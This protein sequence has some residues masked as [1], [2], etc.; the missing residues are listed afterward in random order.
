M[1]FEASASAL[2]VVLPPYPLP[3]H[4]PY[5]CARKGKICGGREKVFV[6]L[7]C[8]RVSRMRNAQRLAKY[9]TFRTYC[10]PTNPRNLSSSWYRLVGTIGRL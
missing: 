6:D 1:G 9:P 2:V 10:F 8:V 3:L 7:W 4:P 5:D